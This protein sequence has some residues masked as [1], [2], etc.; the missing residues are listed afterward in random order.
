[1][2]GPA[3]ARA[4]PGPADRLG[5]TRQRSCRPRRDRTVN[6]ASTSS[7][8]LTCLRCL[9]AGAGGAVGGGWAWSTTTFPNRGRGPRVSRS[10]QAVSRIAGPGASMSCVRPG[11]TL[12]VGITGNSPGDAWKPS[13]TSRSSWTWTSAPQSVGGPRAGAMGGGSSRSP[14]CMRIFR[15]GPGSVMNAISRMSPPQVGHASGNS[16]PTRGM[17]L[18]QAIRDASCERG[19]WVA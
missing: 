19:F 6:G 17:S 15:I 5:R 14:R 10:A 3:A 13:E 16:S 9:S 12:W 8:G 11:D 4:G 1:M 7:A 18:A 2:D